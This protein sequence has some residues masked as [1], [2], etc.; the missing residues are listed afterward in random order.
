[1]LQQQQQ[2]EQQQQQHLLPAVLGE[3]WGVFW[4]KH[5][6]I[7]SWCRLSSSTTRC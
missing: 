2:Q 6:S 3:R 5:W 4:A 7:V 1:M